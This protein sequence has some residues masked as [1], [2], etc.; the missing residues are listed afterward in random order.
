MPDGDGPE[1]SIRLR[2]ETYQRLKELRRDDETVLD[3]LNRVLP[4]DVEEVEKLERPD[5]KVVALPTPSEVSQR[6]NSL[7]G[8]NVSANDVIDH[9]IDEHE[10][11]NE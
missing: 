3:A 2:G 5:D 10:E 8:N 9:L 11:D 6:V 4:D 1:S 7:A